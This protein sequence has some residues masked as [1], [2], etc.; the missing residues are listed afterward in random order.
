[1]KVVVDSSPV[2]ELKKELGLRNAKYILKICYI[3]CPPI[4]TYFYFSWTFG[5]E[6]SSSTLLFVMDALLNNSIIR[7]IID[8]IK[9]ND[10][11]GYFC[12]TIINT[13]ICN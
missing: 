11:L 6:M 9:M 5:H 1:M 2:L 7:I 4:E 8:V 3:F 13:K 10:A 12:T